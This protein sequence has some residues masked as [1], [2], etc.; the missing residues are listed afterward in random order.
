MNQPDGDLGVQRIQLAHGEGGLLTRQLEEELFL[1]AFRNP[2]L[3]P[4]NDAS[5]IPWPA[6]LLGTSLGFSP[7]QPGPP[8]SP[9]TLETPLVISTDTFVVTPRQFPGGDIGKL[10]ICGTLNDLAVAGAMPLALTV[11]LVIEEGLPLAELKEVVASLA[12]TAK[13][14][15]VPIVGGDTKV[16]GRGEADGLFINTTGVGLRRAAFSGAFAPAS[17]LAPAPAPVLAPAP[18]PDRIEP[19]DRVFLSGDIGRHGVA[20]L[21]TR[22]GLEF[23]TPVESDVDWIGPQVDRLMDAVGPDALHAMRDPTRGGLATV[24][25]ELALAAQVAVVLD[26]AAIPVLPEVAAAAEWLGLDPLYLSCEGR[27]VAFVAANKAAAAQDAGLVEIGQVLPPPAAPSGQ[28]GRSA[29]RSTVESMTRSRARP[30]GSI[31]RPGQVLLRTRL[32]AHRP[33]ELL[34]GAPLPRIC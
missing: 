29:T 30:S 14:A 5:A 3:A 25:K 17:D 24:V 9:G 2:A 11:A 23:E 1:P 20:I 32:G 31:A 28:S 33:L 18:A 13:A 10:A 22:V 16:V 26:E 27:F 8:K 7:A 21:A 4:L 34:P 6:H 15:G 12:A 19:G